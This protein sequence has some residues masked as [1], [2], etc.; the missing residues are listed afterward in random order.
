MKSF[1]IKRFWR[2]F[3]WYMSKRRGVLTTWTLGLTIIIMLWEAFFSLTFYKANAAADPI[4]SSNL[5]GICFAQGMFLALIAGLIAFTTIFKPLNNKQKRIAY[6]TLPATN[7][8][9]YL[10]CLLHTVVV[11]PICI[12]LALCLGD[13]LRMVLFGLLGKGWHSGL[14]FTLNAFWSKIPTSTPSHWP[15]N[16]LGFSL[17]FWGI[18]IYILAGS[19]FRKRAFAIVTLALLFLNVTLLYTIGRGLGNNHELFF[20]LIKNFTPTMAKVLVSVLSAIIFGV[21]LFNFWL[22]YRI[23]KRF[24]IITSNWINV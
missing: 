23:F 19:W 6:L 24:Q 16:L 18:S 1:N 17:T 20:E 9:R 5:P 14:M 3:R 7:Q 11:W 21:A 4:L 10:T 2:T 15:A 8:E 22:S 13:T 12:I